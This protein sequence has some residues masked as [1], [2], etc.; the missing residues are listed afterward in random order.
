MKPRVL[1]A[2][3]EA[4]IALPLELLL[5]HA[6]CE[7]IAT[8]ATAADAMHALRRAEAARALPE[9]ALMDISLEGP[10]DGIEAAHQIRA[11]YGERISLIFL[12]GRSDAAMREHAAAA[13]P[14]AYLVKPC[15][16]RE[17]TETIT[18][19]LDRRREGRRLSGA[20][21]PGSA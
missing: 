8:V 21:D 7:V 17:I 1:L 15:T 2:E 16:S 11:L 13:A 12:T 10:T 9:I 19:V 4:L 3:D 14:A 5:E 20:G 6:G 18:A